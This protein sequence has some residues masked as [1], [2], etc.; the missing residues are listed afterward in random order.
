MSW[1][2]VMA[3]TV[4]FWVT[5]GNLTKVLWGSFGQFLAKIL[6]LSGEWLVRPWR[7]K[8]HLVITHALSYWEQDFDELAP[9]YGQNGDFLGHSGKNLGSFW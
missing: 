2:R 8:L 6:N 1:H 5:A 7:R 4:V 3:K 9:S